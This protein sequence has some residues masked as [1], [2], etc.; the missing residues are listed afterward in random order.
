[1]AGPVNASTTSK[2]S[3]NDCVCCIVASTEKMPMRL[4]MK[5]GVSLARITPLPSVVVRNASSESISAASVSGALMISTR[6]MYRGGLKKWT[7]QKRDR[8]AAGTAADNAASDRPE[9]F[10][11]RIARGGRCG[12]IFS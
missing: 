3:P 6:Y 4:A 10:D 7:P 8:I 1:M 9:V 11:A 2:P 12:A 5:L